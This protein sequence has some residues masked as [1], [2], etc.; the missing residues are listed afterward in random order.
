M[1]VKHLKTTAIIFV[2]GLSAV[3]RG[4]VKHAVAMS[5][6][7]FPLKNVRLLNG[8]F[9][10]AMD[11]DAQYLL[12]LEPDRL[13][14][15]FRKEAGLKPKA[16]VY[17]GWES[18][19]LAGHTLG[20]YLSAC[21]RM[22]QDTGNEQFRDRVNYIVAQ[23][24]ECQKANG[25]GYV[26]AIPDGKEVFGKVARGEIKAKGFGL[27]GGW[28]PWYTIHKELAGLIDAY[29]FCGDAQALDVATNLA[30]WI[31]AT[32]ANLTPALWQKMLVCEYGGM[33]EALA[34]LYG[35][36]GN[37]TY[38]ALSEKFYDK[39]VL[40]PL[41]AG[42]D[43]LDGKHS[44]TQI[45]KI[46]GLAREYELTG[47]GR[48]A[49]IAKFFWN[50]VALHRSYVIGGDG[51][52]EHFFPTDEFSKHLTAETAE[53]CCTYN[54]LKLTKHLFE[55]SPSAKEMDFYERAL[56]N[57]ILASQDPKTGMFDYFVSLKPGHFMTFSTPENSFWCCV[58]TGM[59]NH[60]RYGDAIY[61]HGDDSLYVNLFISSK[62]SW[63]EKNLTL[64]QETKFPDG[65]TT[66]LTFQCK[67]PMKLALKIRWPAWAKKISV[68][69]NGGT[70]K[71]S[72]QPESYVTLN[73]EWKNGDVVEIRLPMK[74]H[75]EPLPG[76][77]NMV[78]LLYGPILL[79]GDLGTNG[80]PNQYVKDQTALVKI[81]DPQVPVFVGNESSLLKHVKATNVPLVFRTKN[82]GQPND[83]TLI[84]FFKAQHVRYNVYWTIVNH[85]RL[86]F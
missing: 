12:S 27:N 45:P 66:R 86:K 35:L 78:A 54:M 61:F 6:Q 62:L 50:R 85:S 79:A 19:G 1:N 24:A 21:S 5:V 72:G 83:V 81:P 17:G 26:A 69:V 73:R 36:T 22:Y 71:I 3:C 80:I 49:D 67:E 7:P 33:N 9:K 39:V 16:P 48:D 15:W 23:L 30:N 68:R 20:H 75:A 53:T 65:D 18:T 11:R 59:E 10:A 57:D 76:T 64:R 41:A 14:S 63:P 56:Y 32:T 70:Q 34:N 84:P 77:T 29:Q 82:L 46:I 42:H 2:V 43:D 4:D 47:N 28:S 55:W 25:N 60:A 13:L 38:L 44:N 52:H 74:L 31:D 51:N 40:D 8:P 58:G 37:R